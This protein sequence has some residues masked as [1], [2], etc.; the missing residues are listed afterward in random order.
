M[1]FGE[2][3]YRFIFFCVDIIFRMFSKFW[4]HDQK[5]LLGHAKGGWV[6][7]QILWLS[8]QLCGGSLGVN[9]IVLCWRL[10]HDIS[11]SD[12]NAMSI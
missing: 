3:I 12:E 6:K 9:V 1:I 7:I 5:N 2:E 10:Y 11:F 8:V 4:K